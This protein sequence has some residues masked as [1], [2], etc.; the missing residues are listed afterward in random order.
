MRRVWVVIASALLVAVVGCGRKSYED[1]LGAT[2]RKLEY[3]R[4]LK[5]NLM[6]PPA[7]K[8][9]Q[10]LQIY[11]RAP[12]DQALSKTGQLP[13]A[14]GQFDLDATFSEKTDANLH[15]LARVKMPKKAPVQILG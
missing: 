4:P 6:D 3:D 9:F 13:V 2:L 14:E 12:K 1:R 15:I 8:K 7:E 5:T 11:V 10:E